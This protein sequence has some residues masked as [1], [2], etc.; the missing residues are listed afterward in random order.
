MST[1]LS[2]PAFVQDPTFTA[3]LDQLQE[4]LNHSVCCTL[5]Y[6]SCLRSGDIYDGLL[7]L[8]LLVDSYSDAYSQRRLAAAN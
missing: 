1:E 2:P 4:R 7:D 8:Y 5:V 6:G 3:L